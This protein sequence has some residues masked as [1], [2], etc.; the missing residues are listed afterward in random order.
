MH[1]WYIIYHTL[2]NLY[3]IYGNLNY[4]ISTWPGKFQFFHVLNSAQDI[5]FVFFLSNFIYWLLIELSEVLIQNVCK[6]VV[7]SKKGVVRLKASI[8]IISQFCL[9]FTNIFF[10]EWMHLALTDSLKNFNLKIRMLRNKPEFN[11][12]STSSWSQSYNLKN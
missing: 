8:R 10:F 6:C 2:I 4:Y 3:N 7:Y 11:V 12:I 9:F 5:W 1:H